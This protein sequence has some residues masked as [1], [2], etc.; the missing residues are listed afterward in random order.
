MSPLAFALTG[1][2]S[3]LLYTTLGVFT[4]ATVVGLRVVAGRRRGRQL[5]TMVAVGTAVLT[6]LLLAITVTERRL[7]VLHRHE[8]LLVAAWCV[9]ALSLLSERRG[10]MPLLTA[11]TGPT[12]GLLV[13]FSFVV[14]LG[15]GA[16]AAGEPRIGQLVHILL[17]LLGLA[18]FTLSAGI[19]AYYLWQ[20]RV[21][22][23]DPKAALGR[24]LPSL[25]SL[26]RANVLAAAFGLPLLAL[27]VLAGWLFLARGRGLRWW[28]DPTVLATLSGLVVYAGLF[29]ARGLL[30]WHGR[31]IAW[32]TVAGFVVFVVGFVVASFC[33]SPNVVHGS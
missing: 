20:I 9:S 25:E 12:V 3:G 29:G 4:G 8:I 28:V 26:D 1:V 23:R 30:G 18:S 6:L 13:F 33:T 19:G 2:E 5:R 10:P 21:V 31:R 32:L 24:A 16:G 14:T 17:A 22:K 15:G 11:V 7:P 27:A